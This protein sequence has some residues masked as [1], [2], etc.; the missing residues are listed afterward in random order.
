MPADVSWINQMLRELRNNPDAFTQLYGEMKKPMYAVAYRITGNREDAEDSVADAFLGILRKADTGTIR[1]GR[2]YLFQTVRN[3]AVRR[4]HDREA[5]VV[6]EDPEQL[7]SEEP[8]HEGDSDVAIA[9]GRLSA[10][11]RQ[12]VSLR[13]E[14]E[15]GYAEI[16]RITGLSTATVFRRYRAAIRSMRAFF[17]RGDE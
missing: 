14:A 11:E 17:A 10:E 16:A 2:A 4:L 13:A 5:L 6:C 8:V 12:I 1:N 15:L 3:E 7:R 9:M